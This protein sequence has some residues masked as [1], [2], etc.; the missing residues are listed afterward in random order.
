MP[1]LYTILVKLVLFSVRQIFETYQAIRKIKNTWNINMDNFI[2]QTS[3]L[4]GEIVLKRAYW[5]PI[6]HINNF[7]DLFYDIFLCDIE[8]TINHGRDTDQVV[9]IN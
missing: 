6:F 2:V 1:V 7:Y 4:V 5:A 3:A 8:N 9:E